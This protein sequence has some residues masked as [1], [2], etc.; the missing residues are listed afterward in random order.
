MLTAIDLSRATFNRIRLN[1]VWAMGY[2]VLMI[3]LAAGV[4]YPW[5]QMQMPPWLAGMAMAFSSISV[6]CSSLLL[7][8]YKRPRSVLR[9]IN[10][11]R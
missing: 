11:R 10:I 3:P 1:Y 5:T 7:K 6:V 8:R 9:D 4:F 2:N